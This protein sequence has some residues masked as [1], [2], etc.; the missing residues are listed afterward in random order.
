VVADEI[1][2][3]ISLGRLNK[4][5][6]DSVCLFRLQLAFHDEK[7]FGSSFQMKGGNSTLYCTIGAEFIGF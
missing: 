6:E 4:S 2:H 3:C 7:Y 5:V 1:S